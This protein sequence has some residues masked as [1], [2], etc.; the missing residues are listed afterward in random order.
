M[1]KKIGIIYSSYNNYNLLEHEVLKRVNFEGYPVLNIDDKSEKEEAKYGKKLCE[2]KN[3]YFDINKKKGLQFAVDQ[4]IDFLVEKH[5][6]EWVFCMQQDIYPL[7]KNFFSNFEKMISKLKDES[8]GAMGF[9]VISD[10]EI[11]MNKKIIDEYKLGKKPNGLMGSFPLSN[12]GLNFN[13]LT[14]KNKIKYLLFSLLPT[15][16]NIER[17]KNILFANMNFAEYTLKNFSNISK[18]YKGI[19]AIEVP[20]WPAIAINV[21][22]WKKFIKPNAGYIFHMW[23]PDVCFKFL[24]KN[25]WIVVN[26]E[27]Y[28]HNI[29]KIK[30]KY[31]YHWSSA[32]AGKEKSFTDNKGNTQVESYGKHLEIFKNYWGF[33]YLDT[34]N[35]KEEILSRYKNTL[36]EKFYLHDFKKGPLKKF[37]Y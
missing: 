5:H 35:H 21:K 12:M 31:G 32:H 13:N 33:D 16:K 7:G 15:K 4:G 23:F 11:Y 37:N 19:F 36:I 10:D 14:L 30:K 17:K 2:K 18:K 1:K 25:I 20:A 26:S 22:L 28:M 29:Q 27:F 6:V 8:I 9:N 34:E 3:L 24:Q